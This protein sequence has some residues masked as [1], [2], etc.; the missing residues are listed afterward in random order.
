MAEDKSIPYTEIEADAVRA[1]DL[2]TGTVPEG[3]LGGYM[4][5]PQAVCGDEP[6]NEAFVPLPDGKAI[7]VRMTGSAREAPKPETEEQA[8]ERMRQ[9]A[10]RPLGTTVIGGDLRSLAQNTPRGILSKIR[11]EARTRP[12]PLPENAAR[13]RVAA[14][15]PTPIIDR[16]NEE[17]A[18][19]RAVQIGDNVITMFGAIG[20][21]FWSEGITAKQVTRQLRAIGDRPVEVHVNSPGGDMFEGI[22]IYNVLREHKQHV[23]VKVMGLAA[24]AASIIT[25]AADDVQIGA[26]SFLMIHNCS[27]FAGGNRH[28]FAE[29]AA[30]LEPFDAAMVELYAQRTGR[31][32][33]EIGKWMDAETFMSGSTA[34]D[35]GFADTMLSAE[36]VTVD[37]QAKVKDVEINEIRAMEMSLITSGLS[38]TQARARIQKLKGTPGAALE[39]EDTPGAVP[40]TDDDWSDMADVAAMF[41]PK[42]K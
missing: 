40:N 6:G 27:V 37:E 13:K 19:V 3:K 1:Q 2:P 23:T 22:A 18:G 34:I 25:M 38:R 10:S 17:A 11:G 9:E 39:P 31:D 30:F 28:D 16:W 20:E 15:T 5:G 32:A 36:K 42:S 33:K 14:F 24:S 41:S 26:A 29:I 12:G 8:Q 4:R 21:D 7:P 35:R